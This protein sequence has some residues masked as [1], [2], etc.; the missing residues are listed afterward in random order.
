VRRRAEA[1]AHVQIIH[2][3]Y[4]VAAPT[5]KLRYAAPWASTWRWSSTSTA[6]S[7]IFELCLAARAKV[8][9]LP[10]FYRLR[11]IPGVGKILALTIL[12]YS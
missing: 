10:N 9:D 6:R 3:Q 7:P 5:G 2:G 12:S 11:S 4:N 8:H 1:M